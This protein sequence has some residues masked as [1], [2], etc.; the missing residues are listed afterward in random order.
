MARRSAFRPRGQRS[1]GVARDWGAGTGGTGV[2]LINATGSTILGA[3]VQTTGSELTLLRTRGIVD[4]FTKGTVATDGNGFFGAVGIGVF[5]DQAFTAGVASLPTP[6]TDSFS[7]VWLWHQYISVHVGDQSEY[8]AGPESA[9]RVMIDSKAMRKFDANQVL[10]C[11][12]EVVEIGTME[13][14]VFHDSR[15]LFQDSGR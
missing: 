10:A 2:T 8:S 7:N 4:L 3:G 9:Q 15:I 5:T 12:L 14:N 1:S 11:I 6:L 13:M